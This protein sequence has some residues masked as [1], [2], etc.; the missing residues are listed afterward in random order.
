MKRRTKKRKD[1]INFLVSTSFSSDKVWTLE[2]FISA[3]LLLLSILKSDHPVLRPSSGL[4]SSS[5][6]QVITSLSLER[7]ATC[8]LE[9]SGPL[10]SRRSASYPLSISK[11]EHT[12]ACGSYPQRCYEVGARQ[13]LRFREPSPSNPRSTTSYKP[14]VQWRPKFF[15]KAHLQLGISEDEWVPAGHG[16]W[17]YQRHSESGLLRSGS[18][19]FH[20]FDALTDAVTTL[21]H[22]ANSRVNVF[23]RAIWTDCTCQCSSTAHGLAGV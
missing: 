16:D 3:L 4:E 20:P 18:H 17:A 19:D 11:H 15:C 9:L 23:Q 12:W 2:E 14:T 21:I 6:S 22:F 10:D 7:A 5:R 8:L 13:T 1:T